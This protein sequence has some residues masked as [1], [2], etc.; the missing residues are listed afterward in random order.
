M[1]LMLR[2]KVAG[3][4]QPNIYIDYIPDFIRSLEI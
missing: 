1:K 3:V 2:A 4:M